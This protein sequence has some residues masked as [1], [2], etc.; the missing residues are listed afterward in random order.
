MVVEI[1]SKDGMWQKLVR[2]KYVKGR[3]VAC[4]VSRLLVR[5]DDSHIHLLEK[6]KNA[7]GEWGEHK[8]LV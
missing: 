7:S 4:L 5:V 1:E 3:H 6:K 2:A 8:L